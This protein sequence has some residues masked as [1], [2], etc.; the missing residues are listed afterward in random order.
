MSRLFNTV[1]ALGALC[2]LAPGCSSVP[3][4]AR[5]ADKIAVYEADPPDHRPYRV[6][7]RFWVTTWRSTGLVP[8]YRA[9]DEGRLD[10]QNEAAALGG[11]AIMNFGCYRF[12]ADKSLESRPKMICNGNVIKFL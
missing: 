9:V 5:T 2:A 11:D 7:K 8:T 6:V 4:P 3:E 1:L 12:D 10:L